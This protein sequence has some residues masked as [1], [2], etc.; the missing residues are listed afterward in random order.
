M[1]FAK[2]VT[3]I[4]IFCH[5]ITVTDYRETSKKS[6]QNSNKKYWLEFSF[7]LSISNCQLVIGHLFLVGLFFINQK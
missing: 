3:L 1:S 7:S 4:L 2:L 5:F 6:P